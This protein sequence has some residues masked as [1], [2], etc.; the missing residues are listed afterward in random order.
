M[1]KR[2]KNRFRPFPDKHR[3][4]NFRLRKS[5]QNREVFLALFPSNLRPNG[6]LDYPQKRRKPFSAVQYNALGGIF[7][8]RSG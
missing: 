4:Q 8:A 5:S 2:A 7:S 3:K 6:L 1:L